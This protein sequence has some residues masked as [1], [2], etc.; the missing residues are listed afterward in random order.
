M[1]RRAYYK[2]YFPVDSGTP[3]LGLRGGYI[4]DLL[5][6]KPLVGRLGCMGKLFFL[7]PDVFPFLRRGEIAQTVTDHAPGFFEFHLLPAFYTTVEDT[8]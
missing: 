2:T 8:R 5:L 1:L 3:P 6:N 7:L 4:A